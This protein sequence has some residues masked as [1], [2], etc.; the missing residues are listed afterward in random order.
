MEEQVEAA[1][2]ATEV[3]EAGTLTQVS[4]K[5]LYYPVL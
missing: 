3:I 4:K 1:L 2:R 5:G